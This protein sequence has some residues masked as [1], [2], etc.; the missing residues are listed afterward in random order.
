MPLDLQS[1]LLTIREDE[2]V[3]FYCSFSGTGLVCQV[4]K[5]QSIFGERIFVQEALSLDEIRYNST[6]EVIAHVLQGLLLKIRSQR[7]N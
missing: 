3:S 6:P 2:K 4:E 5:R 7:A 1:L